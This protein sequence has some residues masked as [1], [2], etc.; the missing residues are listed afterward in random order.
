MYFSS[1]GQYSDA[2]EL[3]EKNLYCFVKIVFYYKAPFWKYEFGDAI[4]S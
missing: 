1:K 3:Q 4:F 2:M